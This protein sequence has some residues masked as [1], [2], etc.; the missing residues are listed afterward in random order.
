MTRLAAIL[1]LGASL[2]GC[3][4]HFTCAGWNNLP[5]LQASRTDDPRTKR[6]ILKWRSFANEMG[7][8]FKAG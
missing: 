1:L 2:S 5:E 4:E 8:K 6:V 3:M 7:C